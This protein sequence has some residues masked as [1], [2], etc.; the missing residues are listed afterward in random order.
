MSSYYQISNDILD[1]FNQI[2]EN[3]GEVTDEQ[4]EQLSIKEDE[5]RNAFVNLAGSCNSV[6]LMAE[7][8][9]KRFTQLL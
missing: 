7:R 8:P 6:S 2:E 9:T 4:L 5:L 3:D 1:I